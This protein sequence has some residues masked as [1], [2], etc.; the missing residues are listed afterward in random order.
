MALVERYVWGKVPKLFENF[1]TGMMERNSYGLL[2]FDYCL[3]HYTK[4][5]QSAT[6]NRYHPTWYSGVTRR[7]GE[8]TDPC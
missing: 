6:V 5:E 1:I 7:D 4:F 2:H 8:A 3:L